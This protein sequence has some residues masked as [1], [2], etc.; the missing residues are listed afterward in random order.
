MFEFGKKHLIG[1]IKVKNNILKNLGRRDLELGEFFFDIGKLFLLRK[2]VNLTPGFLVFSL[3]KASVPK[4]SASMRHLPKLCFGCLVRVNF[5]LQS[6]I[7]LQL[8]S[9]HL[10]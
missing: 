4:L 6:Q 1:G 9:M 7:H 5:E 10:D 3:F 8:P 2:N